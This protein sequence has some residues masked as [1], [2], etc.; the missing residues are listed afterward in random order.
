MSAFLIFVPRAS[1]IDAR[2]TFPKLGLAELL[3][4]GLAWEGQRHERSVGPDNESPGVIFG[5]D[6][7][8]S[9]NRQSRIAYVA[10]Q[11]LWQPAKPLP[12]DGE[13]PLPAGRFWLG[14]ESA[15]PPGPWDLQRSRPHRGARVRLDDGRE[16]TVPQPDLLPHVLAI[17]AATGQDVYVLDERFHSFA[18]RAT[19]YWDLC[20]ASHRATRAG[21]TDVPA[22][23][24][25]AIDLARRALTLNYVLNRDLIDALGLLR[26]PATIFAV[27]AA[28]LDFEAIVAADD[29]RAAGIN[30]VRYLASRAW[31]NGLAPANYR[32]TMFDLAQL[33]E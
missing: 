19:Q 32:P 1:S 13:A 2:D 22:P 14:W 11:Q 30:T 25:E 29:A 16:W 8:P 7:G 15:A 12:R 4:D 28:V 23:T 3:D 31:Q 21:K 27:P 9:D 24:F 18:V 20:L 33:G 6:R 10:S 17:D 5:I 26:D